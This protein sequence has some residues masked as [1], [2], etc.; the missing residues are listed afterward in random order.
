MPGHFCYLRASVKIWFITGTD[1][2]IGFNLGAMYQ[3]DDKTRVG[4][5]YRSQITHSI[6]G[7]QSITPSA[8]IYAIPTL[9]SYIAGQ[10]ASG[11]S[12]ASTRVTLPDSFNIGITRDITP[13]LTLMAE[14]QWTDWSLLK[15]IVVNTG[16]ATTSSSLNENWR[17]T[18]YVG[19][20]AD[21]KLTEKLTLK[22]GLGYDQSPVTFSNRTS[23]IPDG[24]RFI[25][26][27]GAG[28]AFTPAIRAEF[29]YAH[30]FV[31][32]EGINNSSGPTVGT[33][34]GKYDDTAD[35]FGLSLTLKL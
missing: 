8:A 13:K 29:G 26:G 21:Y 1:T 17:D 25:V 9:G 3:F 15:T 24:D 19:V 30:L 27:L 23:R 28:Y 6:T 34:V 32:S 35:S 2:G 14:A 33:L 31:G 4:L 5:D 20:G 18:Y 7:W 16:S 12:S 11:S 22:G 10:I